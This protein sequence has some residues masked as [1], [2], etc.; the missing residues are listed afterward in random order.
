M[1]IVS[2]PRMI[3]FLLVMPGLRSQILALRLHRGQLVSRPDAHRRG[4]LT[5]RSSKSR[6]YGGRACKPDSPG[7]PFL[8]A[9]YAESN[10]V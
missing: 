7:G 3:Y 10:C 8:S 9:S 2:T 6:K 1:T 4:R 5:G